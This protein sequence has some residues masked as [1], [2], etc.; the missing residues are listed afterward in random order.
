[1]EKLRLKTKQKRTQA[2]RQTPLQHVPTLCHLRPSMIQTADKPT[3]IGWDPTHEDVR[4]HEWLNTMKIRL[5]DG[6]M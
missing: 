2:D 3:E 1:M 4:M 6:N 5:I